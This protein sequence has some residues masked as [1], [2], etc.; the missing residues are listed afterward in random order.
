MFKKGSGHV[1]MQDVEEFLLRKKNIA[2][3]K[4]PIFLLFVECMEKYHQTL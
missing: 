4:G 2:N 1:E 3:F